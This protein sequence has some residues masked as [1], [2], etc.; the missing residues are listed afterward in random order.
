[1]AST[2]MM[3]KASEEYYAAMHAAREATGE[4]TEGARVRNLT[5]NLGTILEI[6][7]PGTVV[8]QMDCGRVA[9]VHPSQLT[10]VDSEGRD[11]ETLRAT[12]AKI[13][14]WLESA[15]LGHSDRDCDGMSGYARAPRR[16]RRATRELVEV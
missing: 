9:Y 12:V 6:A 5:G 1:M 4:I 14:A 15:T 11:A 3:E 2:R 8:V 13:G 10:R 7:N 16:L